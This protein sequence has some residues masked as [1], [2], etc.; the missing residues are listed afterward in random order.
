MGRV[1]KGQQKLSNGASLQSEMT[2]PDCPLTKKISQ[3]RI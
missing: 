3:N 1:V 2:S